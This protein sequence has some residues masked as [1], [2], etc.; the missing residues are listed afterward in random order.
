M[1]DIISAGFSIAL[2]FLKL[3]R[4]RDVL[5]STRI[6]VPVKGKICLFDVRQ[7]LAMIHERKKYVGL[8]DVF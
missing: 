1:A 4:K 2:V 7:N 8:C 5:I 6:R 3:G